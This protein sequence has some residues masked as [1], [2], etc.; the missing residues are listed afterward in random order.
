M[1]Y[2]YVAGLVAKGTGTITNCTVSGNIYT[3]LDTSAAGLLAAE[4]DG[5]I[6]NCATYG[7]IVNESNSSGCYAGGLVG[8]LGT[9]GTIKDSYSLAAV[10]GADKNTVG[11]LVGINKGLIA[12]TYAAGYVSNNKMREDWSE[13]IQEMFI[14]LIMIA[15]QQ[16]W[17]TEEKELLK[18]HL[19]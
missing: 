12:N 3:K 10:Y 4:F 9:T 8:R 14:I 2:P 7:S 5:I 19:R 15:Y 13:V 11:G 16:E 18:L 1:Y 17:L 6:Q